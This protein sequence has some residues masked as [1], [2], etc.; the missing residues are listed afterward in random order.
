[1]GVR[2]SKGAAVLCYGSTSARKPYVTPSKQLP[3]R[4]GPGLGFSGLR[5]RCQ[6]TG[7]LEVTRDRD[8]GR[9]E[10][11]RRKSLSATQTPPGEVA[12]SLPFP[13]APRDFGSPQGG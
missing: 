3:K 11:A 12:A 7:S 8:R 5:G 6:V 13:W 4:E 1:V 9:Q 2:W 10:G